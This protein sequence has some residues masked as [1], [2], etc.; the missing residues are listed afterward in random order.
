MNTIKHTSYIFLICISICGCDDRFEFAN[1]E[2]RAPRLFF[3]GDEDNHSLTDSLKRGTHLK[4]GSSSYFLELSAKDPEGQLPSVNF[5]L[6]SGLAKLFHGQQ[7]LAGSVEVEN[8]IVSLEIVPGGQGTIS[9]TFEATD[10][11]GKGAAAT[12]T[13]VTFDNLSPVAS[14]T[15]LPTKISGP[16]E[17]EFDASASYDKDQKF[18]GEVTAYEYVI[19]DTDTIMTS[20]KV[21]RHNFPGPGGYRVKYRVHDNEGAISSFVIAQQIT[22]Q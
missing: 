5:R 13:L 6:E 9:I 2:N 15:L 16:Y 18:G 22:L 1:R 14:A 4:I 20:N 7:Q 11:I 10:N 8:G 21:I 3:Y 12:F 17:F 19:N